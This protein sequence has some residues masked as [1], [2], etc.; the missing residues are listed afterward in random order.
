MLN[1]D[2]DYIDITQ[3]NPKF[4]MRFKFY[5]YE[6]NHMVTWVYT[7]TEIHIIYPYIDNIFI[8][9]Q[10]ICSASNGN[11]YTLYLGNPILILR[12]LKWHL[13]LLWSHPR[14]QD[15]TLKKIK[16]THLLKL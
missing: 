9:Y 6:S 13:S 12:Q 2:Q 10:F 5:G 8:M 11:P 16:K 7:Y 14:L 3:F 4:K 1:L 15:T